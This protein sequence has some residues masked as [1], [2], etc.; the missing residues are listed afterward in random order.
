MK[1][2][3]AFTMA[4]FYLLLTTGMFACF[5]T[6]GSN[7]VWQFFATANQSN[8]HHQD[9]DQHSSK[10]DSE[11]HCDGKADC[12]CCDTHGNFTVKEN[13]KPD[14][15]FTF[16]QVPPFVDNFHYLDVTTIY[17]LEKSNRAWPISNAPPPGTSTPIYLK[18]RSLL[19]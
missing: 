3:A 14:I 18:V 19:I 7:H 8:F 1:R 13:I 11:K 16:I 17:T 9:K 5:V 10:K 2:S 12:S 4:A 15:A 6:C